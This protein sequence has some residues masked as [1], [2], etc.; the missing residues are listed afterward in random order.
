MSF[1]HLQRG[2]PQAIGYIGVASDPV[3]ISLG[4]PA[5]PQEIQQMGTVNPPFLGIGDNAGIVMPSLPVWE[6]GPDAWGESGGIG[7]ALTPSQPYGMG[8]STPDNN[9]PQNATAPPVNGW[10]N[11]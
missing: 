7:S 1:S 3:A 11:G 6:T 9:P 2:I 8:G 5:S 10:Y 4:S